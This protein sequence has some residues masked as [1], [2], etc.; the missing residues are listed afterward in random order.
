MGRKIIIKSTLSLGDICVLTATIRDIKLAYPDYVIDVR[1]TF[2]EIWWY[3]P[4]ITRI[5][6]DD[7]DA[8]L[9]E[10]HY[11]LVNESSKLPYHFIHG[12]RKDIQK[13]L[14]VSIPSTAFHGDI[15]LTKE[16]R[17]SLNLAEENGVLGDYWLIQAGGKL[18]GWS[19]KLWH[20]DYWQKIVDHFKGKI[21][22]VQCGHNGEFHYHSKLNNVLNLVGKEKNLRDYFKLIYKSAGTL[23]IVTGLHHLN[24]AI[25]TKYQHRARPLVTIASGIEPESWER[26]NGQKYLTRGGTLPCCCSKSGCCWR[27]R[28]SFV[29]D[30]EF[31]EKRMCVD[32]VI[33]PIPE[34]KEGEVEEFAIS[35]CMELIKPEE[36]IAA[37]EQYYEGGFLRYNDDIISQEEKFSVTK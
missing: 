31:S 37:I 22:F 17:E 9:I 28:S 14:G 35:K 10:A 13:K 18:K 34:G 32:R 5:K 21:T 4:Y 7:Q 36:V 3:N 29:K 26:Y 16:E 23:S 6:D 12:Y 33:L 25:P 1:T 15:F 20:P 8:E 30:E 27:T 24:R 19:G 11:P 2:P